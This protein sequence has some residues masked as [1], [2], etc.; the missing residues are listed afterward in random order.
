M[1]QMFSRQVFMAAVLATG[2]LTASLTA[3]AF[4][5]MGHGG[6]G[7]AATPAPAAA[8]A[9][10]GASQAYMDAMTKMDRD[11]ATMKMTGKPGEDFAAMMIP[12]HQA[13]IDMAKA[14]LA[15]GENNPELTSLSREI[16]VAQE[17]EIEFLR[18]WLG[19]NNHH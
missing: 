1:T 15:S 9:M 10:S 5:Q 7:A 8:P 14:Y 6:H 17:R 19:S 3:P 18:S 16:I 11:M 4:A 2:V 12:H 13:A